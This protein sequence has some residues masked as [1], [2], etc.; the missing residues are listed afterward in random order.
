MCM[1]LVIRPDFK[2]RQNL[3]FCWADP[4]E[5][6]LYSL[7]PKLYVTLKKKNCSKLYVVL[8]YQ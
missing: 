4:K 8:Q 6:I 7:H 1:M 5:I 2:I 3:N